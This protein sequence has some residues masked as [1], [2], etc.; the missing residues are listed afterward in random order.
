MERTYRYAHQRREAVQRE[1]AEAAARAAAH[2]EA[3]GMERPHAWR[4][5][6]YSEDYTHEARECRDC[7]ATEVRKVRF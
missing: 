2:R 5:W 6:E 3:C 1:M 4:N 7:G